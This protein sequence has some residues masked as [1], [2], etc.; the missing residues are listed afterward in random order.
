MG[1]GMNRTR[2]VLAGPCG[3][4]LLGTQRPSPTMPCPCAAVPDPRPVLRALRALTGEGLLERGEQHDA[5]E[6]LEVRSWIMLHNIL[7][8]RVLQ[9]CWG[10]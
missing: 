1:G 5:A 10:G 8:E 2:R 4:A 7:I 9:G 3:R 6:G